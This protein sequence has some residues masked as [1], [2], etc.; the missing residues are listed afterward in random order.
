MNIEITQGFAS[1]VT[2]LVIPA[3]LHILLEYL[4]YYSKRR[5]IKEEKY[6]NL[7]GSI[8]SLYDVSQQKK[9]NQKEKETLLTLFRHCWI[10][11]PDK[12]IE[13]G[14]V[15]FD[16]MVEKKDGMNEQ[17]R[18]EHIHKKCLEFLLSIRRDVTWRTKIKEFKAYGAGRF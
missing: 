8:I 5:D 7:L 11:A 16:A 6:T 4:K 2:L 1:L 9:D 17:Q 10:Y 3:I 14:H 13:N 15:F 12:V 18:D